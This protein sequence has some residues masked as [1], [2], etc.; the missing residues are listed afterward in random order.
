MVFVPIPNLEDLVFYRENLLGFFNLWARQVLV[1]GII[2]CR[3]HIRSNRGKNFTFAAVECFRR[4]LNVRYINTP[5]AE[6]KA[7][8]LSDHHVLNYMYTGTFIKL[9]TN[10]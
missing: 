8:R 7:P 5:F 3:A 6:Y 2:L 1:N 9:L 10:C 4:L